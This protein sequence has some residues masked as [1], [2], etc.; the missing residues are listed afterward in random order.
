MLSRGVVLGI[1]L[2]A[3]WT[4]LAQPEWYQT[5]EARF[6]RSRFLCGVGAG[7]QPDRAERMQVAE[8]NAR[9]N[10]VRAIRTR[11]FS[12]FVNET[13]E[14]AQRI[15]SYTQGRIVSSAALEV[16]G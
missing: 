10:L 3:P 7:A 1:V 6:P 4:A 5:P 11:I 14:S 16:D 13:T 9:A 8:E 12:E 15:D 2:A